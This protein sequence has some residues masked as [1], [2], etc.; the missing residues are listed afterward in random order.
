MSAAQ[1]SNVTAPTMVVT[2]SAKW[3]GWTRLTTA[4]DSSE[5]ASISNA[6]FSVQ[7]TTQI[8]NEGRTSKGFEEP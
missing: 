4:P 2:G 8:F 3:T 5:S 1:R 7:F 6:H